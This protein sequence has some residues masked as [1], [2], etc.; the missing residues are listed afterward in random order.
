MIDALICGIVLS[1]PDTARSLYDTPG[2]WHRHWGGL[3]I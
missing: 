1:G 3:P 2:G